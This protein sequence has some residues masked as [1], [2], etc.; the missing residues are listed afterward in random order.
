[1]GL[2][3]IKIRK[4][5]FGIYCLCLFIFSLLL[6]Q[7]G[8]GQDNST[9]SARFGNGYKEYHFGIPFLYLEGTDYEA[10]LQYGNL[11]KEELKAMY[12]EFEDFKKNLIDTEIKHLPWYQRVFANLFGGIVFNHQVSAYSDRLAD[13]IKEQIRGAADGS[14]VPISFFNEVQVLPDLYAKRC[15]GI[16]IIKG[17]HV[18]HGHNLDQPYPANLLAKYSVVVNYNIAGKVKFTNLSFA[19]L[20]SVTT[21]C[22]EY[23]ISLSENGNNNPQPFDNSSTDLYSKKNRF[24]TK[25]HSLKEVD[26]LMQFATSPLGLLLTFASSKEKQAVVY[27]ILGAIKAPTPVNNNQFIGNR[28][29]SAALRKKCESINSG[30]F[31]DTAREIKFAELID[32]SKQ[33]MVDE[34]IGILSN[35]DFYHYTDTV[36]T[37]IEALHNYETD[38]SVVFDLADSTIYFACYPHFAAW[39]RWLKYN[40]ITRDVSVYKEA[41]PRLYSPLVAQLNKIFT[42]LES[43]DWRD[44]SNV[45]SL[46]N[47]IA[48]S[49]IDNYFSGSFLSKTYLNY[50]NLPSESKIFSDRLIAKYPDIATGYYY[51]GRALEAEQK[52]DEAVL[53]YTKAVDCRINCEFFLAEAYEHLALS[54]S[55][56]ADKD[57][58]AEF[59][60]KALSIHGKYWI[61]EN[62]N[63]RIR[64]LENIKNK[65]E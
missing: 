56:L 30:D 1:M 10:G 18:Y 15:E 29:L 40:Y 26:S 49:Q 22:N 3:N 61:P 21:A 54:Y 27:D 59:A 64:T 38:Q 62:M 57:R 51:K 5:A 20:F 35:V 37:Y 52:Y 44:S 39:S 16:V 2:T 55:S 63:E 46:V 65:A 9:K 41:D 34:V 58:A 6:V 33:N 7:N 47:N 60:V 32:T 48:D 45:R 36:S 53:L 11:L 42:D 19:A 31:H 25:T 23:G 28:A 14:G 43:C 8:M 4:E 17:D 24:I 13:D 50:Y 12:G